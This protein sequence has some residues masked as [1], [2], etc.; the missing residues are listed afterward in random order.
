M[1]NK[2]ILERPLRQRL[3]LALFVIIIFIFVFAI[4]LLIL[5]AVATKNYSGQVIEITGEIQ[6]INHDDDDDSVEIV[7]ND[8]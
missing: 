7:F 4:N 3:R 5:R 1:N 6:E 2:I 8:T